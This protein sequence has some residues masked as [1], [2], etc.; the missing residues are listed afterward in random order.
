MVR[1]SAKK[2][3]LF[4]QK[5]SIPLVL[6]SEKN[7]VNERRKREAISFV[8]RPIIKEKR[9]LGSGVLNLSRFAEQHR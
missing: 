3:H 9:S 5:W 1:S 2:F 6:L 4:L 7:I 8:F